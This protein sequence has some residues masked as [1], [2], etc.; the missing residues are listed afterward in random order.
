MRTI[1]ISFALLVVSMVCKAQ[2]INSI[3]D[4]FKHRDNVVFVDVPKEL[5]SLGLK[6][7]GN[8]E[9]EKWAKKID[10]LRI[11]TLEDANR[12]TKRDFKKMIEALSWKDYN[13]IVKVNDNGE[14]VRIMTQ[15]TDELIKRLI[16]CSFDKEDCVLVVIDGSILPKD[17]DGIVNDTTIGK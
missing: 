13:D 16:I 12:S 11:L 4:K 3:V 8:K 2:D 10:H 6:S 5:I 14:K 9:S 15:G 1:L 7:S 17:I